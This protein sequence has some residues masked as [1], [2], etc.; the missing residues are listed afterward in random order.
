MTH[1]LSVLS[2]Y[3]PILNVQG[4]VVKCAVTLV[5]EQ[6]ALQLISSGDDTAIWSIADSG[7]M[8]R[9]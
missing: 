8:Y 5:N 3:T 1:I 9:K 7:R 4:R 2:L 6:A